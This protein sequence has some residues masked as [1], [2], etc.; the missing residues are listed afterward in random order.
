[1]NIEWFNEIK[2]KWGEEIWLVNEEYCGKLLLIKQ[3][4][5]SSCHYH[6]KKKETFYCLEGFVKLTI[7]GKEYNL[8]PMLRPKTILP[9][10]LHKFKGISDAVIIEIS[11]HHDDEDV[12]RLSESRGADGNTPD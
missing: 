4:A 10:E 7:Q 2:K 3:G 5:E 12:I 8:A 11:T 6:P 1:M 9:N